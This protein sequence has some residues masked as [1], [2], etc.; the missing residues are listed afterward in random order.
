MLS[1]H[2]GSD[3]F[4]YSRNTERRISEEPSPRA[5]LAGIL[6]DGGDKKL[7][8]SDGKLKYRGGSDSSGKNSELTLISL[9]GADCT[10]PSLKPGRAVHFDGDVDDV[11]EAADSVVLGP[12]SSL[13]D[14]DIEW[15]LTKP[16]P[17]TN[18]NMSSMALYNKRMR[19]DDK[20]SR[21]AGT[22]QTSSTYADNFVMP[23]ERT[24]FVKKNLDFVP[25][26]SSLSL[27]A[28]DGKTFTYAKL[29]R[30]PAFVTEGKQDN[31]VDK[32]KGLRTPRDRANQAATIAYRRGQ[33]FLLDPEGASMET[34]KVTKEGSVKWVSLLHC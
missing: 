20:K 9:S 26:I 10:A 32:G 22:V 1:R 14:M 6:G 27:A 17:P 24:V 18:H 5:S 34:K 23:R 3:E 8:R 28:K 33:K 29:A 16:N 30:E 13:A 25:N 7:C 19:L 11:S 12:P 21:N 2:S 31:A 4:S 15:R